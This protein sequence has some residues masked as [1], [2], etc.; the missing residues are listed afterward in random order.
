MT[1]ELEKDF[2][3][4]FYIKPMLKGYLECNQDYYGY[5]SVGGEVK[6]FETLEELEQKGYYL[7][8]YIDKHDIT[9][10]DLE[11]PTITDSIL[12]KLENICGECFG[13]DDDSLIFEIDKEK[14]DD[15]EFRY[16]YYSRNCSNKIVAEG[17]TKKEALLELCKNAYIKG[18]ICSQVREL[19]L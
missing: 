1:R 6:Y 2:F 9:E 14:N 13:C 16:R 17:K 11:Y 18:Y 10:D 4:A 8:L 5:P 15:I 12:L 19:F 3:E 7:P